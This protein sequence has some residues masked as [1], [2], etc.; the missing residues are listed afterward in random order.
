MEIK[1]F[2]TEVKEGVF[3]DITFGLY[4][5]IDDD[6]VPSYLSKKNKTVYGIDDFEYYVLD[7][8]K[9]E[10]FLLS[11]HNKEFLGRIVSL[12]KK[13]EGKDCVVEVDYEKQEVCVIKLKSENLQ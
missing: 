2:Y 13:L 3:K 8:D 6:C 7:L 4:N 5:R 1:D 12:K 10:K 9:K 11:M